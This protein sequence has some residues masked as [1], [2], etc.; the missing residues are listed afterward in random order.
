MAFLAFAALRTGLRS[1]SYTFFHDGFAG[2]QGLNVLS[3]NRETQDPQVGAALSLLD[4]VEVEFEVVDL[5][6]LKLGLIGEM[7]HLVVL[8]FKL[9][10][11]GFN[12]L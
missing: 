12:E 1:R 8:G 4:I 6:P 5:L 11:Q 7:G 9:G 3:G 2:A 10:S